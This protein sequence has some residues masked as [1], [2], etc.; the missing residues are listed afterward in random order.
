MTDKEKKSTQL[1]NQTRRQASYIPKVVT[2]LELFVNQITK[3]GK[4][5][6]V[7]ISVKINCCMFYYK[8]TKLN[9]QF[10]YFNFKDQNLINSLKLT[11]SRDF[12]LN[13]Q[14]VQDMISKQN[15]SEVSCY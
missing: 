6:K 1:K 8:I 12:R 2:E 7:I 15:E 9:L 14:K 13:I 11:S 3:L 4:K 5:C 10:F